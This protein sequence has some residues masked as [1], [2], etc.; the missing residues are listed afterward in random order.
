MEG[1]GQRLGDYHFLLPALCGRAAFRHQGADHVCQRRAL[2]RYRGWL[3]IQP[4]QL[5]QLFHQACGAVA[6]LHGGLQRACAF[7]RICRALCHLGLHANPGDGVRSSW[8]A[9]AVNC[10]SVASSRAVRSNKSFNAV[11]SGNTSG[12]TPWVGSG[13]SD[14]GW[15]VATRGPTAPVGAPSHAR[16]T[17]CPVP[18]EARP[19]PAA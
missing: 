9:S 12:G 7:L 10:C 1:C 8:A 2:G 5:Q 11:T 6:A 14:W 3:C 17:R 4:R 13:S 19:R 18:A 15:R 16:P